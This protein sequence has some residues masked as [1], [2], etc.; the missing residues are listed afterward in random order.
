[1]A[2]PN[3]TELRERKSLK[4]GGKPPSTSMQG[5]SKKAGFHEK[6]GPWPGAGGPTQPRDRSNGIP[7]VKQ[8]PK[9][10]GL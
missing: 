3:Y 2:N 7:K 6:P 4:G 9:K 8:Y 1:M 5:S 10:D